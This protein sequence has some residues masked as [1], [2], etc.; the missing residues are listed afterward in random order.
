MTSR[1]ADRGLGSR[2]PRRVCLPR[3]A[4]VLVFLAVL[5]PLAVGAQPPGK[6]PR[7]GVLSGATPATTAIRYEAL[8]RGLRELGYVEGKNI[9][10][11]FRYAEGRPERLPGLVAE[12]V[13]LNVDVIVTGGDHQIRAAKQTTQTIPIVVALAG[14]LIGPGH[15]VS[16]AR[17]GGNVTG[18][19][20]SAPEAGVKRLELLKATLP[21]A[22]RIGMLW[23]PTNAVNAGILREMEAAAPALGLQLLPLDVRTSDDIDVAFRKA[24]SERTDAMI[25]FGDTVLLTHRGRIVDFAARNRLP[26][27][28]GNQDYMDAGGL[29]FYGPN[30][31]E[32]YRRA[33][34]YVDKILKG[35]KPGD[36]PIEQPTKFE[37]IINRASRES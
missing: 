13:R 26:A 21:R 14:D 27:M 29:M 8:R 17:P 20:T 15:A 7:V 28:Y 30:V 31:A 25:A 22:S 36:L 6:M 1:R 23:N 4:F 33:A 12:L 16:L 2:S 32:M 24:L 3:P 34:M 5:M 35:A 19:T 9:V 11:E 18:L 10:L 37:L